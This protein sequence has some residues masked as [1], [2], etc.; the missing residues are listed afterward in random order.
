MTD[1]KITYKEQVSA[2]VLVVV[3]E[4]MLT[5]LYVIFLNMTVFKIFKFR[6]QENMWDSLLITL[7]G[8]IPV[9]VGAHCIRDLSK[10][11]PIL[12]KLSKRKG[13]IHPSPLHIGFILWRTVQPLK[14]RAAR[15]VNDAPSFITGNPGDWPRWDALKKSRASG[16]L[17]ENKSNLSLILIV[18]L[19]LTPFLYNFLQNSNSNSNSNLNKLKD[20]A[21]KDPIEDNEL[22]LIK[23][24]IKNKQIIP[25][26]N[27][28]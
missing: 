23:K 20:D 22:D 9:I 6:N 1:Q 14:Y 10:K 24:K 8:L 12:N 16:K 5:F 11:L 13:Y 21:I 7:L 19:F 2:Y 3:Y 4:I 26:S 18:L 27:L 15:A 17:I 25:I 28:S